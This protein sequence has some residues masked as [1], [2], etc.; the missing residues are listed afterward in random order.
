MITFVIAGLVF[1]GIMILMTYEERV[2]V[3]YEE[4]IEV[5]DDE[6]IVIHHREELYY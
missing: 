5:N 1:V 2:T 4:V 3:E 6:E